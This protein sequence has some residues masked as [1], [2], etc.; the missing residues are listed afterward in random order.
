MSY[1]ILEVTASQWY[2]D[3]LK[4]RTRL[5]DIEVVIENLTNAVFESVANVEEGIEA[6]AALHNYTKRKTLLTLFEGKT[7]S[8]SNEVA[9]CVLIM[10]S[11]IFF[12]Y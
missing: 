2:D 11:L 12:A 9:V 3:I 5:K 6:L 4:F 8:V 7:T 1:R 10:K